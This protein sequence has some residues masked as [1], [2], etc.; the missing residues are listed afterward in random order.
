MSARG[1]RR[2]RRSNGLGAA[3]IAVPVMVLV[4]AVLGFAAVEIV[5]WATR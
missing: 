5:Q 3:M 2:T 1:P 4:Y